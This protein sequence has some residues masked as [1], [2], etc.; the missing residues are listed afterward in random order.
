MNFFSSSKKSFNLETF[1]T[2]AIFATMLPVIMLI[3]LQAQAQKLPDDSQLAAGQCYS[4]PDSK[5]YLSSL[6]A[7]PESYT[8]TIQ[9]IGMDKIKNLNDSENENYYF[10]RVS[11]KSRSGIMGSVWITQSDSPS[12]FSQMDGFSCAGVTVE[13]VQIVGSVYGLQ[14]VVRD[15]SGY[16]SSFTEIHQWMKSE[17][18][19]LDTQTYNQKFNELRA[20][21]YK[22]AAVYVMA[23][24]QALK[25]AALIMSKMVD[26]S[27]EGHTL[28]KSY[29]TKLSAQSWQFKV[30]FQSAEYFVQNMLKLNGRFLEYSPN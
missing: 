14:P 26:G 30:D 1:A 22:V 8:K 6:K 19:I 20:T 5:N 2:L 24:S 25:E 17:K 21:F 11:C 16:D 28:L 15:F 18:F 12:R 23:D 4:L 9:E 29:V 7:K 10:C 27:E 13:N 3:S